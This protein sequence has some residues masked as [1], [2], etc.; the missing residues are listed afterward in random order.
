MGMWIVMLTI[1]SIINIITAIFIIAV[2]GVV[3]TKAKGNKEDI[4]NEITY[5]EKSLNANCAYILSLVEDNIKKLD[6]L[7]ANTGMAF[8]HKSS[9]IELEKIKK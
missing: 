5:T 8:I 3:K 9:S 2:I 6:I 7:A 1:V 4:K